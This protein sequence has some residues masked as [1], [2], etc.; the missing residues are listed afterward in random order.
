MTT[1]K[2]QTGIWLDKS[3]AHF[4]TFKNGEFN[5]K[6]IASGIDHHRI[7]GGARSQTPYG[8]MDKTSESKLLERHLQQEKTY[9]KNILVET[10]NS[11]EVYLF[12]PAQ[13]KDRL[14]DFLNES[15]IFKGVVRGA[16]TAGKMT[17]N[18][19]V[20]K[21]REFFKIKEVV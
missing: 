4:I 11:S 21:V 1:S 7:G 18:Q 19:R 12:G 9:L 5:Q 3:E 2:I 8:P 10:G 14:R 20:A 15:P 17:E 6:R 16:D 13:M